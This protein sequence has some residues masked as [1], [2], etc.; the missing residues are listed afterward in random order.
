MTDGAVYSAAEGVMFVALGAATLA[1]FTAILLFFFFLIQLR[2]RTFLTWETAFFS[3]KQKAAVAACGLGAIS[4]SLIAARNRLWGGEGPPPVGSPGEPEF[5]DVFATMFNLVGD[6]VSSGP[7]LFVSA[8]GS[9]AKAKRLWSADAGELSMFIL[10]CG[11]REPRRAWGKY[12]G[13]FRD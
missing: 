2:G 3:V 13:A 9:F 10:C 11:K 1:A 7:C 8:G 12:F 4:L 5:R 6:F